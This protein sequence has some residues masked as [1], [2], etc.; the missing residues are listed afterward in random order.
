MNYWDEFQAIAAY[1][2]SVGTQE[3]D[4][5]ILFKAVQKDVS[6]EKSIKMKENDRLVHRRFDLPS[7]LA[8][9]V[10]INSV[11]QGK[12]CAILQVGSK[13]IRFI[14]KNGD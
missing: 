7:P 12:G 14:T 5:E 2:E 8:T 11:G 6:T 13:M 9:K 4:M 1:A 10:E 3:I